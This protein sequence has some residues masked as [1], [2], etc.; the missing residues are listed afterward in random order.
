M[1]LSN[2]KPL[3]FAP[4]IEPW[5]RNVENVIISLDIST[6]LN[7]TKINKWKAFDNYLEHLGWFDLHL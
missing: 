2:R 1:S 5:I 4:R 7:E 3:E 6:K